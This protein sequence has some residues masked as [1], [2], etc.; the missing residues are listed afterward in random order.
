M[1]AGVPDELYWRSTPAEVG[2]LL[3]ALVARES[4]REHSA[5]LRAGLV[6]SAIYNVNRKPGTRTLKPSDFVRER[7]GIEPV[8]QIIP[9]EVI[10][11]AVA[12]A[13]AHNARLPKAQA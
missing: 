9:A 12:V 8:Q 11:R 2:F 1:A 10:Q 5:A 13:T 4:R 6:A 3:A 7:K